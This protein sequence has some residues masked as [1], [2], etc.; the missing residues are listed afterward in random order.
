FKGP[1]VWGPDGNRLFFGTFESETCRDSVYLLRADTRR[2]RR[3]L[4]GTCIVVLDWRSSES[5]QK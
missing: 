3:F 2:A 5:G 4:S 1:L